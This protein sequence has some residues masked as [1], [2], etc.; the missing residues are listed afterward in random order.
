M[1]HD[2][3]QKI[4]K[5]MGQPAREPADCLH[6]LN[7]HELLLE[8]PTL[9]DVAEHDDR[10]EETAMRVPDGRSAVVDRALTAILGLQGEVVAR[11]IDG[12]PLPQGSQGGMVARQWHLTIHDWEDFRTRLAAHGSLLSALGVNFHRSKQIEWA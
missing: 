4:I 3:G 10:S 8:L 7:L 9:G 11:E 2:H 6:F 5:I 1:S 12:D